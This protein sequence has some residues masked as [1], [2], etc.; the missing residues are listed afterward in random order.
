MVGRQLYY[1]NTHDMKSDE[2]FD[3]SDKSNT[4]IENLLNTLEQL[5]EGEC[6]SCAQFKVSEWTRVR[7]K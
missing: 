5:E 6:E 2:V 4:D 3:V 7:L 1:Q